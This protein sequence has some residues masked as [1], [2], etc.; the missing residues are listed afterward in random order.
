MR[1]IT[2]Q[3]ISRFE[4]VASGNGTSYSADMVDYAEYCEVNMENLWNSP[5]HLAVLEDFQ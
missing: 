1:P 3:Q 4:A 5:L 2:V